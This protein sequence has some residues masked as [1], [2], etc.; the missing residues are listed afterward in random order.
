MLA[1]GAGFIFEYGPPGLEL[2]YTLY[3]ATLEV[4]GFQRR[5]TACS[6]ALAVPDPVKVSTT[7]AYALLPMEMFPDVTPLL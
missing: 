3:P 5:L 4:L 7:A 2:R 1:L 6:A